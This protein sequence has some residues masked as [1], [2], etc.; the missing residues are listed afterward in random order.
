MATVDEPAGGP[1]ATA[2]SRAQDTGLARGALSLFDT[3]SSTLAGSIGPEF[4][5]EGR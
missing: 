2:G 4:L 1:T 5:Q 3:I